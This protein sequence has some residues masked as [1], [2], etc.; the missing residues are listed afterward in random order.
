M[1]NRRA[2]WNRVRS[3]ARRVSAKRAPILGKA[4]S[5]FLYTK[6]PV[7]LVSDVRHRT[8]FAARRFLVGLPPHRQTPGKALAGLFS[9]ASVGFSTQQPT[10]RL[11]VLPVLA[12][13]W[14]SR[15]SS[16]GIC[17]LARSRRQALLLGGARLWRSISN[18]ESSMSR[19]IIL[20]LSLVAALALS[21]GA[22]AQG[23][24]AG[25]GGGGA[26]GASGASGTTGNSSGWRSGTSGK[27]VL[28]HPAAKA[29]RLAILLL[30]RPAVR[31]KIAFIREGRELGLV[32]RRGAC[33]D[34]EPTARLDVLSWLAAEFRCPAP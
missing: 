13:R 20:A 30:N 31:A 25:G 3:S 34:A 1:P 7:R 27:S 11:N 28:N 33:A 14:L 15:F 21:S 19:A 4:G 12:A 29:V 2:I 26:G 16:A 22:M 9:C 23:G 17:R 10:V 24:G 18:M 6:R 5:G 32:P 8:N